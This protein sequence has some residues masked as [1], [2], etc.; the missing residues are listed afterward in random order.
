MYQTVLVTEAAQVVTLTINRPAKLNALN[1]QVIAEL[2]QAFAALEAAPPEQRVRA[3]IL[4]GSGEKSFVAGADI[5]EMSELRA[6]QAYEFS[7][8]GHRLGHL[9]EGVSFPI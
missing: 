8:A 1:A 5:A 3:A 9:M 4:T 6:A 7:A 2:T